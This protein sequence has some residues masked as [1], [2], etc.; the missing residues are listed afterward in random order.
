MTPQVRGATP[1]AGKREYPP[2]PK[3]MVPWKGKV[4]LLKSPAEI[5][6]TIVPS[7]PASVSTIS[8]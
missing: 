4:P 3:V 7:G 2:L 5:R 6:G 1:A 8:L